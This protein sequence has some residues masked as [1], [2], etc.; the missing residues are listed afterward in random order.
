LF[1]DGY[2]EGNKDLIKIDPYDSPEK[3]PEDPFTYYCEDC[4][5]KFD[6]YS[7][8]EKHKCTISILKE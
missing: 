7:V 4:D 5:M 2:D 1:Y 6:V 8:F 3:I